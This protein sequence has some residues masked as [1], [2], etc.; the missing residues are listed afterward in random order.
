M[1]CN[2]S[3]ICC[4]DERI[5]QLTALTLHVITK[6]HS[7]TN[8]GNSHLIVPPTPS[9]Y[10]LLIRLLLLPLRSYPFDL[11]TVF[12]EIVFHTDPSLP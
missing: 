5:K 11:H 8:T 7:L 3:L 12:T 9:I 6:V 2:S 10:L 1:F 4:I